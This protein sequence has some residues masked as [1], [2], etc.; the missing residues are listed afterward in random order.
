MGTRK[1]VAEAPGNI[2]WRESSQRSPFQHQDLALPKSP[3]APMLEHLRPNNQQDKNT[4]PP[5]S[6]L[7]KVVL[8]LQPPQNT[9]R[10]QTCPL[11]GQD[12][13]P[14]TRGQAPVPPSRKPAQAHGSTSPTR[15]KRNYDP[16]AYRKETIKTES[17]TKSEDREICCRR[18]TR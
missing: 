6:W 3:Q 12:P 9:P 14:Q 18:G 11:E 15:S 13:T 10:I 16:A 4:E 1:L 5:I 8:S 2:D 17:E 7:P